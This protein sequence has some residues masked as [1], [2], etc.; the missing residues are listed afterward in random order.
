MKIFE[1]ILSSYQSIIEN[2]LR[3]SL[4]MLGII[5]GITSVVLMTTAINGI[6]NSFQQGISALGSDVLY[7]QKR[8]WF[9]NTDWWRVKNRRNITMEDF[10]KFKEFASL[11]IA[12]A[13]VLN[14]MKT[15]KY[16]DKRINNVILTGSNSDYVQTTNFAFNAGR[17]FSETESRASRNV[18]VIGSEISKTLFPRGDGLDKEIKIG[19]EA[20]KVIG[21]LSEQGS[22]LLMTFNP[23]NQ[24]YLPIGTIF[25]YFNNRSA[26]SITLNVRASSPA[27]VEKTRDEAEGVMRKVRGLTYDEDN[28]FA[29]NQQEA[30]QQT[31]NSTVGVIKLAGL[32]I[33][34]L[35][36]FVGAIGIMNIMFVT[37]RER[38]KEIGLR[39]AVGA[40]KFA[41]LGQFIA[42]SSIIC[43]MGG[44]AGLLIAVVLS[45]VV[46]QFLPTSVEYSAVII[47]I[48]VSLLTGIIAGFAPAYTAAKMNPVEALRFE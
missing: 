38:T 22:F 24:V 36:L 44:L 43:L 21:V 33:T 42:E 15:V 19:N 26:N 5:I 7:V 16:Q 27:M 14:S 41:I 6:D 2:K 9:D 10:A 3:T 45:F 12:V 40:N 34:G 31:F 18:A 1:I 23:D 48:V 39:K 17:F 46:K 13:P 35:S 25:K 11:P 28:D 47:A 37:V 4:T 20:F 8:A 30:L 29:I 32:F